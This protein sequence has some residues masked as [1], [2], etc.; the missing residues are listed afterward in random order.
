MCYP[1]VFW[2]FLRWCSL[3][4]LARGPDLHSQLTLKDLTEPADTSR[5]TTAAGKHVNATV[6]MYLEQN[7]IIT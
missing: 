1:V 6:R 7:M 5:P 2:S 4:S 3:T